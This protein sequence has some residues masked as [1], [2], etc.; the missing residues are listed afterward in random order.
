MGILDFLLGI[1]RPARAATQKVQ[2]LVGPYDGP[3][4]QDVC[5]YCFERLAKRPG[6]RTTCP[7]CGRPIVVRSRPE[8]SERVSLLC[9]EEQAARIDA[10]WEGEGITHVVGESFHQDNLLRIAGGKRRDGVRMATLAEL[11]TEP[12]NRFDPNAVVVE[13]AG[14]PV[15]HL[16]RED[17]AGY[18][19]ALRHIQQG[20]GITV[21]CRAFIRGGWYRSRADQGSFGVELFLPAPADLA[22]AA[23]GQPDE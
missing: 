3:K 22:S 15:G 7:H 23:E 1:G 14:L 10:Y 4:E 19:P 12:N 11:R 8:G 20:L 6:R 16:S 2:V 17:A 21:E 5:P 13:I 18:A 9:T